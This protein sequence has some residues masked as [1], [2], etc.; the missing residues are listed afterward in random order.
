MDEDERRIETLIQSFMAT[1]NESLKAQAT[2]IDQ[3]VKGIHEIQEEV[4]AESK[5]LNLTM[6]VARDWINQID[7]RLESVAAISAALVKVET[8][9]TSAVDRMST[10][11]LRLEA[12]IEQAKGIQPGL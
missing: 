5:E 3:L 7:E 2:R 6:Q 8:R 9:V 12:D 4:L 11:L 10:M 1:T